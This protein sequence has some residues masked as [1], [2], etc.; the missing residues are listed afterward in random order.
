ME[1]NCIFS[2]PAGVSIVLTLK[3]PSKISV[4]DSF[5]FSLLFFKENRA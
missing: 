1:F 3:E 4:D 2:S 5:I